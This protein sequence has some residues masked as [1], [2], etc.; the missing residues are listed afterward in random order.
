MMTSHAFGHSGTEAAAAAATS[1]LGDRAA[2]HGGVGLAVAWG[3]PGP[4]AQV[5]GRGEAGDV[6]DL[7]DEHR[8]PGRPDPGNGLDRPI[9]GV[10]GQ[11]GGDPSAGQVDLGVEGV[12]DP[13]VGV[14]PGPV[15]PIQ[16]CRG[17]LGPPG[18]PE[19]IFNLQVQA[20]FGQHGVHP[21]FEPGAHGDELGAVADEFAQLPHRRWGDPGLGQPAHPQQIRQVGGVA[22]VVLHPPV[23]EALDPQRVGQVHPGAGLGEYVGGPVPAVGGLEHHLRLDTGLADLPSQSGRVVHD[24]PGLQ[25]LARLGLAHDH[26]PPPVQID[27]DEL[28]A[29]ILIHQGPP[30]TSGLRSPSIARDHEEREAP[31]L[32]HIKGSRIDAPGGRRYSYVCPLWVLPR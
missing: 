30:S 20:L 13:E 25:V 9:S 14:H 32:H 17:E 11:A 19:Q 22:D 16:R 23:G 27:P 12:D 10:G 29:V 4:G 21:G 6:A 2:V 15:G 24:P 1:H 31:L 8:G 28:S 26:R 5:P 3:E 7:G 18:R